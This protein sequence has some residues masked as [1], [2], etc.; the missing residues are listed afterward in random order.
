MLKNT[1]RIKK[2]ACIFL[3]LLSILTLFSCSTK[4]DNKE[5]IHSIFELNDE[6]HTIGVGVGSH[7]QMLAENELSKAKILYYNSE[8]LGYNA[9]NA[10]QIDAFV[11]DRVPMEL[12]IT[13]GLK[14]V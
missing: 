10:G 5:E 1:I 12:A 11:F 13:S 9:I 14:G 2:F 4:Q 8:S 7:A 3:L 6:K